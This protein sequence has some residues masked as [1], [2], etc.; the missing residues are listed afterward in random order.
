[1]NAETILNLHAE[2]SKMTNLCIGCK[3]FK[4]EQF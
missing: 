1:M 3:L 4:C 2:N